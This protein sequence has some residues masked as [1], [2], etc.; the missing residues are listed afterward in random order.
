[1]NGDNIVEGV[2]QQLLKF[3]DDEDEKIFPSFT[4]MQSFSMISN[5]L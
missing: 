1:M 5:K 4:V 3:G 2:F